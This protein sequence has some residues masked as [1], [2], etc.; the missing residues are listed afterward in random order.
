MRD[1]GLISP[2]VARHRDARRAGGACSR[3]PS[4][5]EG[6]SGDAEERFFS[7]LHERGDRR[8]AAR[9]AAAADRSATGTACGRHR[10]VRRRAHQRSS[11]RSAR[12]SPTRQGGVFHPRAAP[13]VEAL[14]ALG[15]GAVG[16]SSWGPSVYGIVDEP[17]A[18]RRR[19]RWAARGHRRRT[20]TSAWSTSIAGA[21]GWRAGPDGRPHEAARQRRLRRG[22]PAARWPAERTSVDVKDPGEGALGAPA[23][24]VLS[25]VV[26]VVGGAR[27]GERRAR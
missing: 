5:A 18:R 1:G 17:G 12:C 22:G 2:L 19:R 10:R 11:A 7:Q 4:D 15:V 14:L 6:L 9:V 26:Q 16:Q 3:C 27:P 25:E 13:V 21:R 20:P 23:P 24:R 8:R